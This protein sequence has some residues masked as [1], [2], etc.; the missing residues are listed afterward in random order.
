MAKELVQ[1]MAKFEGVRNCPT[2][3][4]TP[5]AWLSTYIK[6][7][8]MNRNEASIVSMSDTIHISYCI[9]A[10]N[11]MCSHMLIHLPGVFRAGLDASLSL[12]RHRGML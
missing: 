8:M 6:D 10:Y 3:L 5:E 9:I 7:M 12:H 11:T 4:A 2:S 1:K